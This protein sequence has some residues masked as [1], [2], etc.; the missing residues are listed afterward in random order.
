MDLADMRMVERSDCVRFLLKP[1]GVAGGE[2]FDGDDAIETCVAG[3]PDFA[4]AARSERLENLVR[5]EPSAGGE[6]R[7]CHEPKIL[8]VRRWEIVVEDLRI[9]WQPW[10]AAPHPNLSLR[11]LK[12]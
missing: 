2:T 9:S 10:R 1:V 6:T 4:H 5:P 11:I 12:S 8:R 3:L 7:R